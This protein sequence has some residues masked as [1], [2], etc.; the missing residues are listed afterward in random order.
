M[1]ASYAQYSE[2]FMW[3]MSQEQE[4]VRL[5]RECDRAAQNVMRVQK[6]VKAAVWETSPDSKTKSKVK[7]AEEVNESEFA[8]V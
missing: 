6:L 4:I 5:Q 8:C 7:Q 2:V 1:P 3:I